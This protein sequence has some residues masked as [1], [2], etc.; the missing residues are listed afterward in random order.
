MP[1]KEQIT[2][3]V[4]LAIVASTAA[5]VQTTVGE[6]SGRITDSQWFALPG[7]RVTVSLGDD[8]WEAITDR[9]GRFAVSKLVLATYRVS[10]ELPGFTT[11][12][13]ILRLTPANRVR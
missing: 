8:R 12:S 5:S 2:G 1:R 4:L 7:A 13:G 3:A 10:V 11:R 9:E 6:I